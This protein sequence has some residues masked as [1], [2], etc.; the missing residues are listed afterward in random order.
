MFFNK[1]ELHAGV[2]PP[3]TWYREPSEMSPHPGV[4]P[5][6]FSTNKKWELNQVL[7]SNGSLARLERVL[8][9]TAL[10]LVGK[11]CNYRLFSL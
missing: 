1:N 10:G 9:K 3:C 8:G 6:Q 5:F 11:C 2:L 4:L 7:H